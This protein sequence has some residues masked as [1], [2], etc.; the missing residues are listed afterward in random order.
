LRRSNQ[1]SIHVRIRLQI[2]PNLLEQ[3]VVVGFLGGFFYFYSYKNNFHSIKPD[4]E[5]PTAKTLE[6]KILI[7]KEKKKKKN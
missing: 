2:L 5:K 4:K 7:E 1:G 6:N 3:P